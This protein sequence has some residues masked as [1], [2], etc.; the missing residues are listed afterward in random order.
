MKIEE[1]VSLI[2]LVAGAIWNILSKTNLRTY[3]KL[4]RR[5][6]LIYV[7]FF[8]N[9]N[10]SGSTGWI[11]VDLFCFFYIR[12]LYILSCVFQY[13]HYRHYSNVTF[14]LMV[15][16]R[17]AFT[18]SRVS[19]QQQSYAN[20]SSSK[21]DRI[22]EKGIIPMV[23]PPLFYWLFS[24]FLISVCRCFH[25]SFLLFFLTKSPSTL[26]PLNPLYTLKQHLLLFGVWISRESAKHI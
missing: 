9:D 12:I 2:S 20:K 17:T 8:N 7:H 22:C 6:T 10:E 11:S 16:L 15:K 4:V 23:S 14:Q 1:Y 3:V 5:L 25:S 26:I 21:N 19:K 13:Q 24:I 18:K